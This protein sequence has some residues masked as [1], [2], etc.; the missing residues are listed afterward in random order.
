[1]NCLVYEGTDLCVWC[2]QDREEH[3]YRWCRR[4]NGH[5]TIPDPTDRESQLAGR[6]MWAWRQ[7]ACA[8]RHGIVTLAGRPLQNE[9]LARLEASRQ[10]TAG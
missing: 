1:M 5:L 6:P 3:P 2:R 9:D 10:V 4:C 7:H 8:C